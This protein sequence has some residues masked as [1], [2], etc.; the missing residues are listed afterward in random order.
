MRRFFYNQPNI[1]HVGKTLPITEDIFH[2]WCKVLRANM[3]EQAI[4]F[5]GLGGEYTVT[6][7]DVTKKHASVNV[8]AYQTLNRDLA[9]EVHIG[10]VMSRGERMDYAIQK[11]TELGV[12]S[13][14]LL[15][16]QHGEVRLKTDQIDKKLAHWQQVAVSACE[17]CGLNIVPQLLS[18]MAFSQ[19]LEH[20]NTAEVADSLTKLILAVPAEDPSALQHNLNDNALV[21]PDMNP[22]THILNQ[23]KQS[24]NAQ[25][26]LLIG[27][28]GG[29]SDE[30]VSDAIAQ[31][32]IPWQI[33][34]RILRTE[35]APV[36][37]LSSLLTLYQTFVLSQDEPCH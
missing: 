24:D 33:G 1:L 30:E 37:A 13:I 22:F 10:L 29:F 34:D 25:F 28:E 8:D 11:S 16:S 27:A 14:Q 36:V 9:F 2:H 23:F 6:L 12:K 31:G 4:F 32:F 18:P 21:R 5:D 20:Q 35:T 7:V 17:Q 19:W 26:W 15:T 3:G